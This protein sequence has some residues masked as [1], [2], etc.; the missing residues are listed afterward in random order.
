MNSGAKQSLVAPEQG[1]K[2]TRSNG[3]RRTNLGIDEIAMQP[4]AEGCAG[5]KPLVF[6]AAENPLVREA[7]SRMPVKGG[8]IEAAGVYRAGPFQTEDLLK[9]EADILLLALRGSMNEDLSAIR[10]VRVSAPKVRAGDRLGIVQV[11]R[12][13]GFMVCGALK[14]RAG[15]GGTGKAAGA[16]PPDAGIRPGRGDTLDQC[17]EDYPS[18]SRELA[19]AAKEADPCCAT[20]MRILMVTGGTR[21]ILA[22]RH[23][24]P[25]RGT[26]RVAFSSGPS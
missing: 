7:L 25:R 26:S 18:V 2:R 12:I 16:K 17:L 23:K 6:V 22:R 8:N 20:E 13:Q 21:G 4:K 3:D 1:Q 19:L 24:A 9:E 10:K 11:C 14:A 5:S 15:L